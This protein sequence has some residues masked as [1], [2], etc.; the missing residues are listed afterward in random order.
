[1]EVGA[2]HASVA[3]VAVMLDAV[4]AAGALGTDA[5]GLKVVRVDVAEAGELPT[6]FCAV[7]RNT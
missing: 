2:V 1:M 3:P 6:L 7:I 5:G 4:G